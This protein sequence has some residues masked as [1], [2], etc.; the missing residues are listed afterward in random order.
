MCHHSFDSV[1]D[2]YDHLLLHI[3]PSP[4]GQ[5][6]IVDS[7]ARTTLTTVGRPANSRG[8]CT[9]SGR[10]PR[11]SVVPRGRCTLRGRCPH[12]PRVELRA[13]T[14]RVRTTFVKVRRQKS[15]GNNGSQW[16]R[17]S[18]GG[19]G[20]V[21]GTSHPQS[22]REFV[23]PVTPPT[24]PGFSSVV[25]KWWHRRTRRT[26]ETENGDRPCGHRRAGE[27]RGEVRWTSEGTLASDTRTRDTDAEPWGSTRDQPIARVGLWWHT[28]EQQQRQRE[29]QREGRQKG[30][31][32]QDEE[33][34]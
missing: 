6:G 27:R 25:N 3:P 28:R 12:A 29:R 2:L 24:P 16:G 21:Q 17:R 4:K 5:F 9:L 11:G 15:D 30:G 22:P 19:H 10:R 34:H 7:K 13:A 20:D 8:P 1:E 23:V 31:K 32:R 18:G 14:I 26:A 33:T